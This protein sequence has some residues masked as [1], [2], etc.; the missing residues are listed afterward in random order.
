M[1]ST[2]KIR[3]GKREQYPKPNQFA[4]LQTPSKYAQAELF[5]PTHNMIERCVTQQKES[6][7]SSSLAA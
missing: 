4:Y 6:K 7:S 1:N 3:E 5:W 2:D